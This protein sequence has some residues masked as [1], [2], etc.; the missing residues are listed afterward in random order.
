LLTW[1]WKSK[2]I[3][4]CE[5]VGQ[6]S[7]M[8]IHILLFLS[9]DVDHPFICGNLSHNLAKN[10][11]SDRNEQHSCTIDHTSSARVLNHTSYL[12]KSLFRYFRHPFDV[13][14]YQFRPEKIAIVKHT[15]KSVIVY[16]GFKKYLS[17]AICYN[18]NFFVKEPRLYFALISLFMRLHA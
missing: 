12:T 4:V 5:G 6:N 8:C 11:V 3:F 10:F 17:N 2:V 9:L 18:T 1:I 13:I 15:E 14:Q 16:F 7:L